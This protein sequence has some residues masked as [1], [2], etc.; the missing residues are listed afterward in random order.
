MGIDANGDRVEPLISDPFEGTIHMV[1]GQIPPPPPSYGADSSLP[2]G[3]ASAVSPQDGRMY[4]WEK[5][6]GKTTWTHP[7]VLSTQPP[8]LAMA[9]A[10]TSARQPMIH[11]SAA[12][13]VTSTLSLD[14]ANSGIIA[15][16]SMKSYDQD[17][18][19]SQRPRTYQCY[20]I[21]ATLLFFPLGL[22]ALIYSFKV[23]SAWTSHRNVDCI[24]YSRRALLFSRISIAV[25]VVFWIFFIFFREPGGFVFDFRPLFEW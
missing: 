17:T 5:S 19:I 7:S 6:T 25:G 20:A 15:S 22:F 2:P 21:L 4:F 8:Y 11:Q 9:P 1:N 18:K 13:N 10:P 16:R 3:W 14:S 23:E 24:R 12:A